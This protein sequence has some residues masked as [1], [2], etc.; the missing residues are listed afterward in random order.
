MDLAK[1]VIELET[2]IHNNT[3]EILR[4]LLASYSMTTWNNVNYNIVLPITATPFT[5]GY[6]NSVSGWTAQLQIIAKSPFDNCNNP[7]Q[8]GG[9]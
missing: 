5:E 8:L 6:N 3:M 7:I 1:D 9:N 4:D 2:N